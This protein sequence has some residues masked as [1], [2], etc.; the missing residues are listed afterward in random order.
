[1][2]LLSIKISEPVSKGGL[3]ASSVSIDNV[4]KTVSITKELS[5][6]DKAL[7]VTVDEGNGVGLSIINLE[8]EGVQH[9]SENLGSHLE[10]TE[11]I[12]VLEEALGVQSV[13][14]DELTELVNN[15]SS[16]RSLFL[17]SL[18]SSVDSLGASGTDLSIKVLLETL[19]GEDLIDSVGEVSPADVSAFLGSL[20]S[21][22]EHGE[23]L[24]GDGGLGHGEADTELTGS[25]VA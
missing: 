9:L 23:L 19:L 17:V 6:L 11:S 5:I 21:F 24:L 3:G 22:A 14:S 18:A 4:F 1:M 7:F 10:V 25:D 12:S 20:E 13:G 2:V 16:D 15:I 8:L